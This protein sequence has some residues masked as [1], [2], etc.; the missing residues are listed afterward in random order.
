MFPLLSRFPLDASVFPRP[1][2]Q[3]QLTGA[4][5]SRESIAF[6]PPPI[7]PYV[8]DRIAGERIAGS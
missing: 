3:M 6:V 7:F 4:R 8:L 1:N 5:V 2:P